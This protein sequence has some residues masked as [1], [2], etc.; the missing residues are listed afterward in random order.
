M[1]R[2]I[3]A[4]LALLDLDLGRT[5]NLD[6]CDASSEL[7][8]AFL[9]LFLVV[10]AGRI[11]DLGTNGL[12]TTLDRSAAPAPSTIVVLSLSIVTRFAVPSMSSVT[13]SSLMPRSSDMV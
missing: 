9:K 8:K 6:D 13:F 10:I 7:G 2:V 1:K 4:I 3:N 11:L 5:A 12:Y